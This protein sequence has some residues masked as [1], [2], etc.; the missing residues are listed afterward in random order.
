MQKSSRHRVLDER[1]MQEIA[2]GDEPWLI[3]EAHPDFPGHWLVQSLASSYYFDFND[4][5]GAYRALAPARL[6]EFLDRADELSYQVAFGEE[7][8]QILE[9]FKRLDDQPSIR[10]D[11]EMPGTINGLF[12]FQVQGFNYL[13]DLD[14]GIAMWST[15]TG[16]TCLGAALIKYHITLGDFDLAFMIVKAHNK[17]NTQRTLKRLAGIDSVVLDGPQK[18]RQEVCADLLKSPSGTV[19]ITNYEKFRIDSHILKPLFEKRLLL[20]WDEMPTKLKSRKTM[21]YKSIRSCLYKKVDLSERRPESLRQYMLSATPIENDP[22]DFFNCCRLLD[23]SVFGT[24]KQFRDE[25]V[26]TYSYFGYE[27]ETWHHL[28]KMGLKVAH[29][30]HQVDKESPDIVD[31]FPEKIETPL[32]IDWDKKDRVV[33]DMLAEEAKKSIAKREYFSDEGLISLI[34]VMQMLCDAPSMVSNSAALRESYESAYRAYRDD[35]WS[36]PRVPTKQGSEAARRLQKLLTRPLTNDN[37]TKLDTLRQLLLEDHPHEKVVIFSSFNDA[38]LPILEKYLLKWQI[39]Y[40][41]YNGTPKQK[42]EAQDYF[43]NE[44]FVRVFL[45]SDQGSDSINLEEASVVINYDLPSKWSTKT[46]RVNRIDRITSKHKTVW[47]YDLLMVNSV[48][49]RMRKIIERKKGYHD[50]VFKGVSAQAESQR[51]SRED[52]IYILTGEV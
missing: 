52:L 26:A 12:P 1:L 11:S 2:R 23:P 49:D 47:F 27:P 25:Y 42:Q 29:M 15:G 3:L 10:L 21:L 6:E 4:L 31:Q 48:E 28:D 17:I 45:S 35:S 9:A 5:I 46:Q 20:L 22:E 16:K 33:Y 13:K 30:L 38:L 8:T 51:M 50:Q 43:K 18:R 14:A 24:T 40:V 39:P 19:V 41:R 36:N 34:G 7:P 37:H 44:D 32:Y